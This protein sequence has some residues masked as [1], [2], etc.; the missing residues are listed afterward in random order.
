MNKT[1]RVAIT[2][3]KMNNRGYE[4]VMRAFSDLTMLE[5]C[6]P[7]VYGS[8]KDFVALRNALGLQLNVNLVKDGGDVQD[9]RVNFFDCPVDEGRAVAE[10]WCQ[11]GTADVVVSTDWHPAKG[12]QP[13]LVNES[14]RVLIPTAPWTREGL[15]EKAKQLRAILR[16]DFMLSTPRI[17]VLA[18]GSRNEDGSWG[19][20]EAE[21]L[22]PA[23]EALMQEN[24][25]VFGPYEAGNYAD[26][27]QYEQ[28]DGIVACTPEQAM[29]LLD[30]TEDGRGAMLVEGL[31]YVLTV[32]RPN[33]KT[34]PQT[35]GEQPQEG[36]TLRNAV[37]LAL[38]VLRHRVAYDRPYR[39]PLQK[40]YHEKKDDSEKVRFAVPKAKADHRAAAP[41]EKPK[42]ETAETTE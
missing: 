16:R 30:A 35:A 6:T 36:Q 14:V 9:G 17:A 18:D 11:D 25:P 13:L 2:S 34:C 42:K 5:L 15:V 28:F 24:V 41:A 4:Q 29:T 39:N 1:L 7:I 12:Q 38:D 27:R 31:P 26:G 3:E 37:Y 19:E 8:Q 40:L 10:A 20:F 22:R 32:V 21:T 33:A 23:V